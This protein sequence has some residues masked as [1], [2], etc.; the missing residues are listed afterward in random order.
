MSRPRVYATERKEIERALDGPCLAALTALCTTLSVKRDAWHTIPM[1]RTLFEACAV[2]CRAKYHRG[3][4][5]AYDVAVRRAAIELGI[6]PTAH[7]R[8]TA[9]WIV[10]SSHA[11]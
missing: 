11:A 4:G 10:A 2:E 1:L 7:L 3:S 6:D 8:V 9:R 5:I